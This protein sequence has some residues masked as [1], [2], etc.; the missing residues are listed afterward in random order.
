M[1]HPHERA[2]SA[3]Y[4]MI[5]LVIS[6]SLLA[7]MIFAVSTLSVS[8]GQ[9]QEYARR[10]TRVT[11]ITQDVIDDVRLELVSSVRL[12][13]NDTEGNANLAILDLSGAPAAI[14]TSRLP[15]VS[16]D[17]T[18]RPDT[19]TT[20]IT[21]NSL[22]FTRLAWSDRFECTSGNEYM[23]DV[24][25]WVY[26][27]LTPEDGGPDPSNPIGLNI[28][29]VESEPLIDGASVDRITD[30]TDQA[31]VLLHL[32]NAT[33]DVNGDTHAPAE[34]VWLRGDLPSVSGTLRQI[35]SSDGSM[36]ATPLLPRPD[37]WQV[38]RSEE[39]VTG[40]LSFRHHSVATIYAQES[41]GVGTYGVESLDDDG[42][43]HG[44]EVQVVG[45]SSARQV[46][47]HLVLSSTQ[48]TGRFAWSN[49]QLTVDARDL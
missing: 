35:D 47:L 34:V 40:L 29:R 44:F 41:F 42:F 19:S 16:A 15:T 36:T 8:G 14:D 6:S 10:L 1:K 33:P 37:P 39:T 11:E 31:E 7:L 2:R 17:E 4:S 3:G 21:G 28:V 13:G 43:P 5:E 27:Y 24:Y 48:R 23:V 46:H 9:A 30:S 25:R 22:F 49:M 12:F 45:P 20:E 18:I 38:L 32:L 26:F